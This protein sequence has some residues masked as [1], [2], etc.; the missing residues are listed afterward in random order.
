MIPGELKKALAAR[1]S[2]QAAFDALPLAQKSQIVAWITEAKG[3]LRVRR[4]GQAASRLTGG[5]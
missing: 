4:A 3:E 1:P 2:A 5:R